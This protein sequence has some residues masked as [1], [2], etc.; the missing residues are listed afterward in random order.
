MST[1]VRI[2]PYPFSKEFPWMAKLKKESWGFPSIE[3]AKSAMIGRF[4]DCVFT[5]KESAKR[6]GG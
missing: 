3:A 6:Q 5:V 4:G 1:K 2:T